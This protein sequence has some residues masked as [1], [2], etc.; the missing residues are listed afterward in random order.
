MG[1]LLISRI[2]TNKE[3][4]FLITANLLLGIKIKHA[5][6][7]ILSDIDILFLKKEKIDYETIF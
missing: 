3:N 5:N 6:G 1:D 4:G 2:K 7:I